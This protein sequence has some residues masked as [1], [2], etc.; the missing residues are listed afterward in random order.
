MTTRKT[1]PDRSDRMTE[2]ALRQKV[3]ATAARLAMA[4]RRDSLHLAAYQADA[5]RALADLAAWL[6]R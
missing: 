3:K 4:K 2:R 5:D 6:R 1:D